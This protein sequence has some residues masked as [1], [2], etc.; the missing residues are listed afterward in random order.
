MG[1]DML[2]NSQLQFSDRYSDAQ[3]DLAI[4]WFGEK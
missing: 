4:P 2:L 3:T 1:S